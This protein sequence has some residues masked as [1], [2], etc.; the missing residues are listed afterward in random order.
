MISLT[1]VLLSAWSAFASTAVD[2]CSFIRDQVAALP[3]SGGVVTIAPGDYTCLAPIVL[4]RS[5]VHLRGQGD[6]WLRLGANVNAPVIVMGDTA[7]PPLPLGGIT[8]SG[9]KIDGNRAHQTYECWNGPCDG[10]GMSFIRN[11]GITVRGVTGG[12]IENVYVTSA[13]SGGVVTEKGCVN[14]VI[15]Q[16][17]AVDNQF[18]GFAGYETTGSRLTRLVLSN[19]SAAGISLDIDF[20][21]NRFEGVVMDH[22]GDVGIFMR[23]SNANLFQDIAIADS[24]SHGAFLAFDRDATTCPLD[25]QF[26][27]FSVT[28][29]LGQGFRLNSNCGG[30]RLSGNLSFVQNRDGCVFQEPGARLEIDGPFECRP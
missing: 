30:N 29:S 11:N 17:T 12:R 9:L 15:D 2:D 25:N 14:L 20:H 6:V 19:N 13:R 23:D 26:H 4:D 10:G 5:F 27:N 1:V 28:R 22:N 8:V 24:A 16:L 21:R 7:T 18:D 3:A